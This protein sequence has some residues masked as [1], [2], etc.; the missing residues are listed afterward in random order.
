MSTEKEKKAKPHRACVQ[1]T[2]C[3]EQITCWLLFFQNILKTRSP[4]IDFK[5]C[6]F[7]QWILGMEKQ[8]NQTNTL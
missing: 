3:L 8:K 6:H 2:A 4:T 5:N 1:E 7:E